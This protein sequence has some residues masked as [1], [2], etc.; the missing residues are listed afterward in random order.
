MEQQMAWTGREMVVWGGYEAV[1]GT[2]RNDGGRYDPT[3]DRW[4]PTTLTGAPS[5]RTIFSSVWTGKEFIIWGGYN[6][7]TEFNTGGR[8]TP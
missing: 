3:T 7:P 6:G 5:G 2:M 8:Y 4:Q 1:V